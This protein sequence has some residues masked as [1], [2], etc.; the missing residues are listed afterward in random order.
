MS[1]P[2]SFVNEFI[3]GNVGGILGIAVVYPLDTVKIRLQT[4]MK[5]GTAT[6]VFSEMVR[7]DGVCFKF[8]SSFLK[9]FILIS[10]F[11]SSLCIGG[12]CHLLWD[13]D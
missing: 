13:L 4:N 12:C 8:L 2:S 9:L 5:Y 7:A 10:E 1:Q 11:R 3:A 6:S